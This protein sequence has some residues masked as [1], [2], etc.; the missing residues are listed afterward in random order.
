MHP[1]ENEILVI[2]YTQSSTP[3][4]ADDAR[5][6]RP[7]PDT[8]SQGDVTDLD[9]AGVGERQNGQMIG[10]DLDDRD[11]GAWNRPDKPTRENSRSSDSGDF[12]LA[13]TIHDVA[14]RQN[15]STGINDHSG[16]ETA[17]PPFFRYL[18]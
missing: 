1:S 13:R 7:R 15:V 16:A 14:V 3:R 5:N 8:Q 10:F 18:N 11:V 17:F 2:L 9:S 12:H 4:R 6:G